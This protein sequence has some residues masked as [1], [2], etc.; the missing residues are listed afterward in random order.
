MIEIHTRTTR[1]TR[2]SYSVLSRKSRPLV[3]TLLPGDVIAIREHR[4]RAS[5]ELP[6]DVV[7]RI[8]IRTKV[9][10]D[11]RAKREGRGTR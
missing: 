7:F 11:R 2:G 4:C 1:K 6:L 8:A 5:F 9:E 10:A 3:V